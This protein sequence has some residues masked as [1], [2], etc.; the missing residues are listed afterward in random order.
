[1]IVYGSQLN[2]HK[3]GARCGVIPFTISNGKLYFLLGIDKKTR[4]LTDFG[5]GVK[6]T[7][8]MLSGGCR[9][10]SE[11]S[12]KIFDDE[13]TEERLNRSIAVVTDNWRAAIIF[14]HVDQK[15]LSL[16]PKVFKERQS[17]LAGIKK[18]QELINVRWNEQEI[19]NKIIFDQRFTCVWSRV[20]NIIKWNTTPNELFLTLVL[21][22][23]IINTIEDTLKDFTPKSIWEQSQAVC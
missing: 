5:G 23:R 22:P 20:R 12:C 6:V 8:T 17:E 7:E 11:E 18:H 14:Y 1:M 9:E 13:V 19:F 21:G 4:D 15:W 3:E 2:I 10:W 16:A